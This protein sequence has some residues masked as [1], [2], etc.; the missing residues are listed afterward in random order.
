MPNI[1]ALAALLCV[2]AVVSCDKN[3][4]QDITGPFPTSRVKF[5]NFGL[6]TPGVNFYANT[7]K[8]TA[9]TS[10]TGTESTNGVTYGN[11]G[12]GGLYS[13]IA[14]GQYS[15]TG[16]IAATIDKDLPIDTVTATIADGKAYSFYLSGYYNTGTKQ[17]DGFTVEDPIPTGVD[18]TVANVRFVQAIANAANPM[19]LYA[20]KTAPP[21]SG[22]VVTVGPG[23][24]YKGATAFTSLPSGTYNLAVRYQDST[25]NKIVRT[26]LSFVGG[27]VYT[28]GAR[29]DITLTTGTL[30]PALDNTANR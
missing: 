30:A 16:R 22:L 21:D 3:L 23:V 14:P 9:I 28:V 29:G 10:G 13:A 2:A 27:R 8:M 25:A 26:G 20:T 11:A 18:F 1:R 12:N 19:V 5:F 7:S 24:S 17:V 15:L 4:V 6:N